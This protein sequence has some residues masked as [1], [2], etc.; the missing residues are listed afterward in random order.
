MSG[1]EK[2]LTAGEN[3]IYKTSGVNMGGE[4]YN[5]FV[6]NKRVILFKEKGLVFKKA[7]V[8]AYN[9][10]D[11]QN[12]IY[13]EE[14]LIRKKGILWIDLPR[15]RIEITGGSDVIRGAYQAIM[16]FWSI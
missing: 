14:G 9:M 16:Q 1:I 15:A 12:V 2:Y 5:L 11:M 8:I 4:T 3:V 7:E 13:K 6:T 10:K